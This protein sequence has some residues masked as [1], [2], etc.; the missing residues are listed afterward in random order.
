MTVHRIDNGVVITFGT[1]TYTVS[2]D[3]ATK[4]Y[5][6]LGR[7]IEIEQFPPACLI[8]AE[9]SPEELDELRKQVDLALQDPEYRVFCNVPRQVI[10]LA[11]EVKVVE[12]P[13]S[14]DRQPS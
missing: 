2:I 12:D 13:G 1:S 7:A 9:L 6:E 11:D 10:P 4:L 8:T 5:H 3:K 14:K